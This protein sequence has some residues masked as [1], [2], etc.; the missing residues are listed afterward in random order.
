MSFASIRGGT[1]SVEPVIVVN[2]GASFGPR[3]VT[4]AFK[5]NDGFWRGPQREAMIAVDLD[6]NQFQDEAQVRRRAAR[7][8]V[9]VGKQTA[10]AIRAGS[11]LP[12]VFRYRPDGE[13]V[14]VL[15]E[16]AVEYEGWARR[17]KAKSDFKLPVEMKP[18]V[19][20]DAAQRAADGLQRLSEWLHT[21][22]DEPENR[23]CFGRP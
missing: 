11:L 10:T 12:S 23:W 3:T 15:F 4:S 20:E 18:V 8:A 13:W 16:R 1:I 19:P 7:A 22:V 9:L 2:V 21:A 17:I 14:G 5:L 6:G